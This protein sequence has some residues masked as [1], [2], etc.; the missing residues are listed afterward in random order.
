MAVVGID[1]GTTNSCVA[2]VKNGQIEIVKDAG[3]G[4]TIPSIVSF[5]KNGVSGE[6]EKV[7]GNA[8][9]QHL[10]T[11][12]ENT[13]YCVKRLMGC[14]FKSPLT[15][16]LMPML[17][18]KLMPGEQGNGLLIYVPVLDK[19]FTAEEIASYILTE[20]RSMAERYLGESVT[21]AV[22]TVPAY[23]NNKQRQ[24]TKDAASIAGIDVMRI[25]NE[26]TAAALAY[27]FEQGK[28]NSQLLSVFDFG[29]G[30]FDITIMEVSQDAF[31]VVATAGNTLLGGEDITNALVN[32]L[33]DDLNKKYGIV[34]DDPLVKVRLR[35]YAETA[36]KNLT[37]QTTVSIEIPY[38]KEV[39]GQ[40]IH[41][42]IDITRDQL[43]ELAKPFI[44]QSISI[45]DKTLREIQLSPDALA[46]VILIGGQTRMPLLQRAIANF[47]PN[48]PILKNI[49]PDETV[50]AGAALQAKLLNDGT[51]GGQNS[52]M[53]LLDVT[54]H[55]LGIAVGKDLFYTLIPKN[56]TVPTSVDDIFVT[57][58]DNQDK[59]KILLL[60]GESQIA[61]ENEIL[62]EFELDGLRPAKRGE[63]KIKVTYEIDINGIVTVQAMDL[64]TGV[65]QRITVAST[66][67]MSKEE[68]AKKIEENSDYYLDLAEKTMIDEIVQ[69]IENYLFELEM[70]KPKLYQI[71]SSSKVGADKMEKMETLIA[72]TKAYIKGEQLQL[73]KLQDIETK[74]DTLQNTYKNLINHSD[75]T[76]GDGG[77]FS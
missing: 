35:D 16:Q 31:N 47:C 25:I 36:K 17:S 66:G 75:E 54:P 13:I 46:G 48:T 62:G 53:L 50:A 8:A 60:Q 3:G 26:P 30:T 63:V 61:S 59:A 29:G 44:D 6:I 39:N 20:L 69:S 11:N 56:S 43:E 22:I 74:L 77:L 15:A 12:A 52:D 40:F 65:S 1:F 49:N 70:M 76:V 45:F 5:V 71:L 21:K 7:C 58:R 2:V 14:G 33:L 4:N 34:D 64:E 23:F 9:R 10:L 57:S 55:N 41:Y 18:Y 19:Y 32:F 38:L 28:N 67:N 37:V 73:E 68:L 24:A 72:G 27:G 42:R 51:L